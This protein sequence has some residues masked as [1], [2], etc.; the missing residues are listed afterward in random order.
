MT[1]GLKSDQVFH[2]KIACEY[3]TNSK[4]NDHA[5]PGIPNKS[6][7]TAHGDST[8]QQSRATVKSLAKEYK[9]CRRKC[10]KSGNEMDVLVKAFQQSSKDNKEILREA[11]QSSKKLKLTEQKMKLT[12]QIRAARMQKRSLFS[13]VI[14]ETGNE[15]SAMKRRYVDY[16]DHIDDSDWKDSQD[17]TFSDI[18]F[19]DE[20]I[21]ESESELKAIK[22]KEAVTKKA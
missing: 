22:E 6:K 14:K 2:E 18:L 10:T 15:K 1:N 3:N 20:S 9:D 12:D 17:S 21:R 11:M 13:E 16:C 7:T 19:E 5:H 8:G 4:Y